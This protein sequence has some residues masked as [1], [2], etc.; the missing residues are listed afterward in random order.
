[1]SPAQEL[2]TLGCLSIHTT[3]HYRLYR[4]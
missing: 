2:S 1:M 3:T 4:D